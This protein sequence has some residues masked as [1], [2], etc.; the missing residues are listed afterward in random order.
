M[1]KINI[2]TILG[3]DPD[4][5][6]DLTYD[7]M[8]TATREARRLAKNRYTNLS[9]Q[10]RRAE[11]PA[12]KAITM[13]G[14]GLYVPKNQSKAEIKKAFV[15]AQRFLAMKTS[16]VKGAEE[17]LGKYRSRRGGEAVK[18]MWRAYRQ[19]TKDFTEDDLAAQGFDSDIIV[20]EAKL[21][22]KDGMR[23]KDEI[24]NALED[25][26]DVIYRGSHTSDEEWESFEQII[27]ETRGR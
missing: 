21:L 9:K 4:M 1:P 14:R 2:D 10:L 6:D 12:W 20:Q 25:M 8:R 22:V 19:F 7:Q 26:R 13:P 3:I 17:Y 24:Y 16:T 11:I 23:D 27:N 18:E 15:S 5:F